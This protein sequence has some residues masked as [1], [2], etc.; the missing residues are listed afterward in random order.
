VGDFIILIFIGLYIFIVIF[1]GW[2][3][4]DHDIRIKKIEQ[5]L[6][7]LEGKKCK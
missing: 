5:R 2:K 1:A 4:K 3:L 6:A 7:E